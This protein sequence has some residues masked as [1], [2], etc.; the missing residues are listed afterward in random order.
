MGDEFIPDYS[1]YTTQEL[2]EVYYRIDINNNQI[3]TQAI[4]AELRK[5]LCL[6]ESVD[7]NDSLVKSKLDTYLEMGKFESADMIKWT[8]KI[9]NGWIAGLVLGIITLTLT[10]IAINSPDNTFLQNNFS[11]YSFIDVII[12]LIL[13]YGVY[14]KN[15]VSAIILLIYFMLPKVITSLETGNIK[16]LTGGSLF[17]YFFVEAIRGIIEYHKLKKKEEQKETITV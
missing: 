10:I 2:I 4:E 11:S 14:R 5:K 6:D 12:V 16:A 15:K 7:L 1:R 9:R 17:I 3:R 13:S 8:K